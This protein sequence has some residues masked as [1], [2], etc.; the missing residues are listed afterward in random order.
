MSTRKVVWGLAASWVGSVLLAVLALLPSRGSPLALLPLAAEASI[1]ADRSAAAWTGAWTAPTAPRPVS[2]PAWGPVLQA[3]IYTTATLLLPATI[4]LVC[5]L[6]VRASR[7][8]C[9]SEFIHLSL[10]AFFKF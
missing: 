3:G 1:E 9:V 6:K 7:Q 8:S 5:N 4:V 2:W 10:T